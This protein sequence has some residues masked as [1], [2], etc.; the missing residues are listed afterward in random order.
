MLIIAEIYIITELLINLPIWNETT[1]GL[2]IEKC[3]GYN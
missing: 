1:V 2:F 3:I